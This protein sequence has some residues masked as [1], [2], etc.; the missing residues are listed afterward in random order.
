MTTRAS[1]L[2]ILVLYG[3]FG[4]IQGLLL[5][6]EALGLL[7]QVVHVLAV[8]GVLFAWASVDARSNGRK[9]GAPQGICLILF[10]YLA[11]PF[12]LAS[13]RQ[14]SSWFHWIVKGVAVLISSLVLFLLAAMAS[15]GVAA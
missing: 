3:F 9:L 15:S 13:Y 2:S 8:G 10:S 5:E 14:E 11:V 12:Y 4:V 6:G 1:I 7:V